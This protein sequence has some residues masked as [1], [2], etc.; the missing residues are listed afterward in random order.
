MSSFGFRNGVNGFV[1]KHSKLLLL[2]FEEEKKM[3]TD[4]LSNLSGKECEEAGISITSLTIH[5]VRTALFGRSVLELNKM[6]NSKLPAHRMTIGDEV[7]LMN[8]KRNGVSGTVSKLI[9]DTSIEIALHSN[10]DGD[11]LSEL[12]FPLRLDMQSSES[13]HKKLNKCLDSLKKIFETPAAPLA[14]ILFENTPFT[15]SEPIKINPVNHNLNQSQLDAVEFCLNNMLACIHG[16]PGTGKTTTV[17]ELCVQACRRGEKLLIVAPSNVATDNLLTRLASYSKSDDNNSSSGDLTP[18]IVRLGH[19]ARIGKDAQQFCLEALVS[20][21]DGT[22]IVN[23]V[24]KEMDELRQTVAKTKQSSVRRAARADLRRLKKEVRSREDKVVT[25]ILNNRN[26]VLT[27]CV[28]AASRVIRDMNF[29]RVIVDEA[30]ASLEAACWIAISKSKKVVLAG[31]H[32]QLSAVVKCKEADNQGLGKTLF[33]RIMRNPD[34]KKC[35]IML[36]IQYR[37]NQVISEWASKQMYHGKLKSAEGNSNHTLHDLFG[38]N[39]SNIDDGII[40]KEDADNDGQEKGEVSN[41]NFDDD[42]DITSTDVLVLIDTAGCG[43]EEERVGEGSHRNVQEVSIVEMKIKEL[44]SYGIKASDIGVITPYRGQLQ[45]LKETINIPVDFN[46]VD[47]FQGSE[48]EVIIV[49][50]VR[51]NDKREVGFLA[52]RRRINVA[53]TRAKRQ[54]IVIADVDTCSSDKFLNGLFEYMGENG[55]HISAMEFDDL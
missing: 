10:D 8:K 2:E 3:L 51:S 41:E 39:T 4:R 16:P 22:A 7:F 14:S 13:T 11:N 29:D 27:T 30:C 17:V 6:N 31:D 52:D 48:R 9:D 35:G 44:I 23:D 45:Y 47:G 54:L 34:L 50:M 20:R 24:K 49:T 19:P 38:K 28:G 1:E 36:D 43:M 55:S 18:K 53:V 40:D 32:K 33:E 15:L 25:E 46:T 21:D 37:M 42:M 26:A 12:N 5:S